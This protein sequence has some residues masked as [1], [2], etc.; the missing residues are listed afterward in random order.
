[1]PWLT[2]RKKL[3]TKLSDCDASQV[4]DANAATVQRDLLREHMVDCSVITLNG[5]LWARLAAHVHSSRFL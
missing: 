5:V 2:Q 4:A 1:M 3:C